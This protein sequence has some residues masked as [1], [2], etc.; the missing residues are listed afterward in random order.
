MPAPSPGLPPPF[1]PP[2]KNFFPQPAETESRSPMRTRR[3]RIGPNGA[4]RIRAA[5]SGRQIYCGRGGSTRRFCGAK[6][7]NSTI[8]TWFSAQQALRVVF[9]R[10]FF[11]LRVGSGPCLRAAD[12]SGSQSG[13]SSIEAP[14]SFRPL[15]ES[16]A[17]TGGKLNARVRPRSAG[18]NRQSHHNDMTHC[19]VTFKLPW[20]RL[21]MGR[22][23]GLGAARRFRRRSNHGRAGQRPD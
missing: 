10:Q 19:V 7:T 16:R 1:F 6:R 4:P 17:K 20:A 18:P 9:S 8:E 13:P 14:P 11:K 21:A 2:K 12:Q 5:P 22:I 23:E 15:F 3:G